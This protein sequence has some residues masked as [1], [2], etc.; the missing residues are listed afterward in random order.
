MKSKSPDDWLK[1]VRNS[2]DEVFSNNSLIPKEYKTDMLLNACQG[3][4]ESHGYIIRGK[5]P[6]SGA[7]NNNKDLVKNYYNRLQFCFPDALPLVDDLKDMTIATQF[8]GRLMRD[9]GFNHTASRLMCNKLQMIVLKQNDKFNFTE[10]VFYSYSVFGQGSMRW[11]TDKAISILNSVQYNDDKLIHQ[12]DVMA[13][14]YLD[15]YKPDL[16]FENL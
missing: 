11:V 16:G 3:L 2:V 1:S 8:V 4:L 7:I 5:L 6:L 15:K 10:N 14:Q 12:A 9:Y 13:Q